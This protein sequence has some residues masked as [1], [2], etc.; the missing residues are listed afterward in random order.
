MRAKLN[1]WNRKKSLD[2]NESKNQQVN[3]RK[4]SLNENESK[5]QKV[6]Y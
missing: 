4:N 2:E 6:K 3:I 5:T 1:R